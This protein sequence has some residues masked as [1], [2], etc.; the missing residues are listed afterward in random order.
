MRSLLRWTSRSHAALVS[1]REVHRS[2]DTPSTRWPSTS[3][4][5]RSP[6]PAPISRSGLYSPERSIADPFRLRGEIGYELARDA[7]KEL[8]APRRETRT[9]HRTRRR[10]PRRQNSD[11]HSSARPRM[12]AGEQTVRTPQAAARSTGAKSGQQLRRRST[13]PA[14]SSNLSRPAYPHQPWRWLHPQGR[15]PARH[16]RRTSG[17]GGTAGPRAAS[18]RCT[19]PP[20]IPSRPQGCLSYPGRSVRNM[21][22]IADIGPKR[23]LSRH[24]SLECLAPMD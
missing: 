21:Q 22:P 2:R 14:I 20:W 10:P 6:S 11:P 7:L 15:D 23:R 5:R 12:I 24:P 17:G 16:L 18:D 1:R 4:A 3:A 13:W 8:A 19:E 9:H